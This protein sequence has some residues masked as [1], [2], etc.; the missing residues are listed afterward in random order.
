MTII[1]AGDL[2]RCILGAIAD[3]NIALVLIVTGTLLIYVEF[4]APG[5]VAPGVIGAVLA[6][7][8][9]SSFTVL[10]INA[11]GAGLIAAAVAAFIGEAGWHTHGPLGAAGAVALVCGMAIL[12]DSSAPEKIHWSTA[13]V[14]GLPFSAITV[15]L[16]SAAVRAR[17]N[18]MET[19]GNREI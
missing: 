17:R 4:S 8:G 16:L 11:W 9:L 2:R 1:T 12:V 3:P 7:L 6:L 14:T 15:V 13:L 5:L 18:K 19:N 10:P